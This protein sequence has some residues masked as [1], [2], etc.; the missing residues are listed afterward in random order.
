MPKVPAPLTDTKISSSKGK[1]KEYTLADGKG[2]HLLIKPSGIKVWE[3]VFTS[4]VT[5]K[6][7]KKSLGN[8]LKEDNFEDH[9]KKTEKI[10]FDT[11]TDL[12]ILKLKSFSLSTA[13]KI[14]SKLIQL[15]QSGIDPMEYE[16]ELEQKENANTNG[17]FQN[18]M[19]EW[20]E[21]QKKI[22]ADVTYIRKYSLFE[23]FV[24]P[25]FKDKHIKDITKLELI[26]LLEEKEKT[27]KETASRLFNYL[28]NLWSYAVLKDYCE[29][30]YLANI[31]KNDVLVEKR[32][33]NNYEKI[34]DEVIFKELVNKIYNYNGSISIKNALKFVLHIP[35]RA[36]NLCFLKWSYIDFEKKILNIPRSE[37]KVKNH[38]LTDFQLPLTSE[39]IKILNDQKTYCTL[40]T[41]LKEYVF[42]GNDNINPI[43]RESPNQALMRMGFTAEKKQSLHSFRGSFR[44]IAEE[45][46]Q[47]HNVDIRIMESILDHQKESKVEQAYK[48]KINYLELQKPL[49]TWWSNYIIDLLYKKENNGSI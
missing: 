37:M 12:E 41:D 13:R 1:S 14:R 36:Y 15:I 9:T 34:T 20:F 24:L 39:V 30:N 38:N 42:I 19:N 33:K 4:P 2:L 32:R 27:A 21:R 28:S 29:Y 11:L 31:N 17:L 23:S 48:N 35:L 7:R 43:N 10:N 26:H 45:K 46:Q 47:I 6:R 44:T 3:F 49:L 16:K 40:Y 8:Y 22:L 5:K 18:V 25:Y